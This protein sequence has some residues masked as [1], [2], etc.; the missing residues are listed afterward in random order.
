MLTSIA[1]PVVQFAA[2]AIRQ[3]ARDAIRIGTAGV[4]LYAGIAAIALVGYGAYLG[5]HAHLAWR[6][7]GIHLG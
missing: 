7:L 5:A 2:P 1:V 4:A 3:G 6:P